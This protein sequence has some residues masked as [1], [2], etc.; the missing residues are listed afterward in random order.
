MN[1]AATL[2][3]AAKP[4]DIAMTYNAAGVLAGKVALV[5]GAGA[6]IGEAIARLFAR[7]GA[8]VSVVDINEADAN[9]VVQ[10]ITQEGGSAVAFVADVSIPAAVKAAVGDSIAR[11]GAL[12]ILVNNAG[13]TKAATV[14]TID[15]DVWMKIWDVNV[16][17]GFFACKQA[18]PHMIARGSGI[19]L[20]IASVAALRNGIGSVA[21]NATKSALVSMVRTMAG[22]HGLEGIRVNA[23]LPGGVETKMMQTT[24]RLLNKSIDELA[25]RVPY[26]K[27]FAQPSEIAEG[28]LFLASDAASY[29]TGHGLVIDGG[30]SVTFRPE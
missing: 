19:I 30:S 10:E 13:I 4:G 11:F 29:I 20:F 18:L 12:D 21:Y 16:H 7:Q 22:D 8:T 24:S 3:I 5:T 6:G 15:E 23:I 1:I 17:A 25:V 27:R 28:A 14:A 9:R 26:Q 2:H